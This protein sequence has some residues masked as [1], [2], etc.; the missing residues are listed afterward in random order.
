MT[1]PQTHPPRGWDD[2]DNEPF[3][4]EFFLFLQRYG[5]LDEY[6]ERR[7]VPNL[8]KNVKV[9]VLHAFI[10]PSEDFDMWSAINTNW[11]TFLNNQ[12][13]TK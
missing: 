4:L 6:I 12:N 5:V 10:W 9:W 7:E 1:I 13:Q 3:E 11:K 8:P 2:D